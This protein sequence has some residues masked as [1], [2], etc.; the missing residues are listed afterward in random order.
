M[1]P[2]VAVL[3]GAAFGGEKITSSMLTGAALIVGAVVLVVTKGPRGNPPADYKSEAG[4]TGTGTGAL[5]GA[6]AGATSV[7]SVEAMGT[8]RIVLR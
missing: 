6:G 4:V 8:T 1:N 2:V 3:L 7:K 5:T